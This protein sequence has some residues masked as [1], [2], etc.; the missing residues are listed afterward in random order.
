[1]PHDRTYV[2]RESRLTSRGAKGAEDGMAMNGSRDVTESARD[3][4]RQ[5]QDRV[6]G[7]MHDIRGYA[8]SADSVIREFAREKPLMAIACAVGVGF[9]IGRL[10]SRT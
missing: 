7:S 1:V 2:V 9:L 4:M 8:G 5:V 6:T 10:A 3:T